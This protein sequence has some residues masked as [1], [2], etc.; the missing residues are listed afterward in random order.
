VHACV[1]TAQQDPQAGGE[2]VKA[3]SVVLRDKMRVSDDEATRKACWEVSDVCTQ[4][5]EGHTLFFLCYT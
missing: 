5:P 4:G 3:S 2:F 1:V